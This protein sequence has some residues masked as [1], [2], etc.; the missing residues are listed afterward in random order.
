MLVSYFT[1]KVTG[2]AAFLKTNSFP[3]IFEVWPQF[4]LATVINTYC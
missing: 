2:D 3:I 1:A 4:Q